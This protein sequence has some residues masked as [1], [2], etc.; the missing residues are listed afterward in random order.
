MKL[1]RFQIWNFSWAFLGHYWFCC[2]LSPFCLGHLGATLGD[3]VGPGGFWALLQGLAPEC[4]FQDHCLWAAP[5][6][7]PGVPNCSS[8]YFSPICPG[9]MTLPTAHPSSA[10]VR[11]EVG[12]GAEFHSKLALLRKNCWWCYSVSSSPM[13]SLC[14]C[15][16]G[17]KEAPLL[18]V[19][20]AAPVLT[21]ITT[22]FILHYYILLF[23]CLFLPL[24]L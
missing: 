2:C 12:R 24:K 19:P 8:F 18:R 4:S 15:V 10:C 3:G 17:R 5:L 14:A 16:E 20:L 23:T 9:E 7:C 11:H 22:L 6:L 21:S 1:N 13:S